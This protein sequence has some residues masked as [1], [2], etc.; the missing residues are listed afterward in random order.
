MG[1]TGNTAAAEQLPLTP[2]YT[3]SGSAA[4]GSVPGGADI[5]G[6]SAPDVS[7]P[8]VQEDESEA[9][10]HEHTEESADNFAASESGAD[11]PSMITLRALVTTREA[12][13][14]IGRSG[15]TVSEIRSVAGVKAGLS[16]TV[17]GVV[18]RVLTVTG[19]VN[20]VA[21]AYGMAALALLENPGPDRNVHALKPVPRLGITTVR[22]LI[23]NKQ[24]GSVIGR[25][26]V[27]I[28]TIQDSCKVRIK[29]SKDKL[30]NSTERYLEIQGTPDAVSAA[31]LEIAQCLLEDWERAAG[32]ILYVPHTPGYGAGHGHVPFSANGLE[33]YGGDAATAPQSAPGVAS[34]TSGAAGDEGQHEVAIP[35]DMVGCIIGK[36]GSRIQEIRHDSGARISIAQHSSDETGTRLF[37][38]RGTDESVQRALALLYEQI[39]NERRRRAQSGQS[40]PSE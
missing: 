13:A 23:P 31:V 14:I 26:G 5:S 30:P 27:R 33:G 18:D 1:D 15:K 40:P 38:I 35:S 16:N 34:Q 39:D 37:T 6:T 28:K 22:L 8:P 21:K 9:V 20:A 7:V 17:P 10:P 2:G 11:G 29:A 24:M 12:G 3:G 36:S 19:E 4:D 25:Q 32:T